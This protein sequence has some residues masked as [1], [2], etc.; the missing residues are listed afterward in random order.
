[1]KVFNMKNNCSIGI[2]A[3]FLID[4]EERFLRLKDSFYSF[5]GIDPSEWIINIRGKFK[6]KTAEFL[7][8]NLKNKVG[9]THIESE[10][11]WRADSYKLA[12]HF[13]SDMIF[14]WLEDHI[15]LVDNYYL[16]QV[17]NNMY[18]NKVDSLI[19]SFFGEAKS[20]NFECLKPI[21]INQYIKSWL[22]EKEAS[23]QLSKYYKNDVYVISLASIMRRE[24]FLRVLKSNKPYLKRWPI[25]T[26]FDFE[27]KN[28]DNIAKK[29]QLG[30][31]Q[32]ELFAAIDDDNGLRGYSLISRGVYPKR[33]TRLELNKLE[34][35]EKKFIKIIKKIIPKRLRKKLS[36]IAKICL[37]VLFTL[38]LV[39]FNPFLGTGSGTDYKDS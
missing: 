32:K 10:N 33:F 28:S 8:K 2:F 39:R 14:I 17:I 22:I 30:L 4:N 35:D 29:Y 19:Y 18:E 16:K 6:E 3:N 23:L 25:T 15:S 5:N 7:L 26:P 37:R 21:I 11:G 12:M 27:K 20:C 24:F 36:Y 34:D 13:R 1:M 31:P 38:R 9:I